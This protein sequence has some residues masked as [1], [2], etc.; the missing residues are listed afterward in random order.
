M[1]SDLWIASCWSEARVFGSQVFG[2]PDKYP[3]LDMKMFRAL[4]SY[5]LVR[6]K[7][8]RLKIDPESSKDDPMQGQ[9]SGNTGELEP[10]Q[11]FILGTW[12]NG[13]ALED[14]SIVI[15]CPAMCR[16]FLHVVC[17]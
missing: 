6:S 10:D 4:D 15:S 9:T 14:S 8:Y 16:M 13:Y 5:R 12:Q 3:W 1:G 2:G 11:N 7:T 17:L